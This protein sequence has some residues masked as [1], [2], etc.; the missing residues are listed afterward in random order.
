MI[1]LK[2][3]GVEVLRGE[4]LAVYKYIHNTHSYSVDHALTYEGYKVEEAGK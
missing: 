3:D 2:R 4:W 1:I